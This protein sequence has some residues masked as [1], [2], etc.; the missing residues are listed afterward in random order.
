[1]MDNNSSIPPSISLSGKLHDAANA[2]AP[3]ASNL[4]RVSFR[5]QTLCILFLQ[6]VS[7]III[8]FVAMVFK[9]KRKE[10]LEQMEQ[11]N[12]LTSQA[13]Q[14]LS[15]QDS[16][17]DPEQILRIVISYV[18]VSAVFFTISFWR[19]S[20]ILDRPHRTSCK[21]LAFLVLQ[22]LISR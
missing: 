8:S 19:F 4:H 20:S 17:N 14:L 16:S 3:N 7:A 6:G 15:D 22:I 18:A 11:D 9:L 10:E 1:M 21:I 13:I 2:L 5:A 12:N